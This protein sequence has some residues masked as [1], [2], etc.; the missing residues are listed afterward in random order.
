[1]GVTEA[2]SVHRVTEL[3]CQFYQQFIYEAFIRKELSEICTL[4]LSRSLC[5]Q[6]LRDIAFI[7]GFS[8]VLCALLYN[9]FSLSLHISEEPVFFTSNLFTCLTC[10]LVHLP[11]YPVSLH[12]QLVYLSTRSLVH[13]PCYPVCTYSVFCAQVF[14]TRNPTTV[15]LASECGGGYSALLLCV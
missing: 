12:K 5:H 8:I 1:M 3:F 13:L 7:S 2:P 9:R 10:P 11:C 15:G 14:K 6:H 4:H